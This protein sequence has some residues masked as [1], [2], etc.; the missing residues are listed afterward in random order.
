MSDPRQG[1]GA[2]F[3]KDFRGALNCNARAE[4]GRDA[5]VR[6]WRFV[7]DCWNAKD[8]AVERSGEDDAKG[9]SHVRARSSIP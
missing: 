8:K 5:R 7:F 6:A 4:Q 3:S 1:S 2:V 9:D